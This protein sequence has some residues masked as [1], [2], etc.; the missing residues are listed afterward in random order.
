MTD[1]EKEGDELEWNHKSELGKARKK[2]K[3]L[4]QL[5]GEVPNKR[6]NKENRSP[7]K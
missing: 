7:E 5:I 4:R 3:S 1:F 2:A 6:T